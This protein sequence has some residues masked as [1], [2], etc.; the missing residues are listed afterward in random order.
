MRDIFAGT[1]RMKSPFTTTI[2]RLV[3]K[4][5]SEFGAS[6]AIETVRC[7]GRSITAWAEDGKTVYYAYGGK[8]LDNGPTPLQ[9]S[10]G[11]RLFLDCSE[12]AV[13]QMSLKNWNTIYEGFSD[14]SKFFLSLKRVDFSEMSKLMQGAADGVNRERRLRIQ[15]LGADYHKWLLRASKHAVEEM[16]D[17]EE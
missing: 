15:K 16:G 3:E 7:E 12:L 14:S 11:R 6:A 2:D 4:P 9:Y 1:S 8:A 10:N 17:V 13:G 5:V